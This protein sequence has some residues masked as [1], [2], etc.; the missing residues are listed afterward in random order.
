[1]G[2]CRLACRPDSR[3]ALTSAH[4]SSARLTSD[5]VPTVQK[6]NRIYANQFRCLAGCHSS[7]HLRLRGSGAGQRAFAVASCTGTARV[8]V[9][10]RLGVIHL[11]LCVQFSIWSCR[12]SSLHTAPDLYAY[13]SGRGKLTEGNDTTIRC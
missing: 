9:R 6:T 10:V 5:R 13:V 3:K 8:R 2:G 1:M 11:I 7:L 4:L 12:M